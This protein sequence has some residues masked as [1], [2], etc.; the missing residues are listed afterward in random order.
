MSLQAEVCT[1]SIRGMLTV[2]DTLCVGYFQTTEVTSVKF[3]VI[4]P[5]ITLIHALCHTFLTRHRQRDALHK[6]TCRT[7]RMFFQQAFP[8]FWRKTQMIPLGNI[9]ST[10]Q[11]SSHKLLDACMKIFKLNNH[12]LIV[13]FCA[14]EQDVSNKFCLTLAFK[15]YFFSIAVFNLQSWSMHILTAGKIT[16]L[17]NDK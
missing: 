6:K 17:L 5:Y 1:L 13:C 14:F 16:N 12:K 7:G 8:C 15:I 10:L 3:E 2:L 4:H 9:L 11:H